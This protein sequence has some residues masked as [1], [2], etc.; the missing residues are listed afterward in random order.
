MERKGKARRQECAGCQMKRSH[1]FVVD[2]YRQCGLF[3][4]DSDIGCVRLVT[5]RSMCRVSLC[6]VDRVDGVYVN[7][8]FVIV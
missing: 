3:Q 7:V 6:C 4:F 5:K 1:D 8:K 2:R